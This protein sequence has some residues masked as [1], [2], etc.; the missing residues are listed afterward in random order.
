M[1]RNRNDKDTERMTITLPAKT[2]EAIV[3]LAE[4]MGISES[5]AAQHL[6]K[7]GLTHEAIALSKG[8]IVAIDENGEQRILADEHGNYVQ[9]TPRLYFPET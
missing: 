3:G 5:F 1:Q 9:R 6:L 2:K 7:I 4:F 8:K